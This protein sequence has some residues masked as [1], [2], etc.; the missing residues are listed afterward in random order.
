MVGRLLRFRRAV[1]GKPVGLA[2][3]TKGVEQLTSGPQLPRCREAE[4]KTAIR[5]PIPETGHSP[6]G[7]GPA[8]QHI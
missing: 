2:K 4:A 1:N 8:G 6:D 3:Q 5:G 7:P